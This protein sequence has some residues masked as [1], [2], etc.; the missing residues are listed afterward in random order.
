MFSIPN[1]FTL[2]RLLLAPLVIRAILHGDHG[3]ALAFFAAAAATDGIDGAL[4]RRFGWITRAGAYLDP[5]AD[6]VLLSGV[7]LALAIAGI[8]PWW[9]V[10]LIFARDLLILAASLFALLFTSYRTFEPSPWGKLSTFLQVVT[11]VA[12]MARNVL[13]MDV[14]DAVARALI[15]P[16]AAAT[17]WSGLHYGWRA[18]RASRS[19]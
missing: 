15:W 5:V 17:I 7:Y 8:L 16:T 11:A 3:A 2:A 18:L 12:W 6:K 4:A 19:H 14:A 1:L 10:G 9:F 13:V